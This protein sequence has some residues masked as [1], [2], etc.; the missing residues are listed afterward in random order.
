MPLP[1]L[2]QLTSPTKFKVF[3]ADLAEHTAHKAVRLR[4]LGLD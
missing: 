1:T 2:L 3:V 4:R